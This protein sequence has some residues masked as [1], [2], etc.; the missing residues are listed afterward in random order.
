MWKASMVSFTLA[1]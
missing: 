1:S